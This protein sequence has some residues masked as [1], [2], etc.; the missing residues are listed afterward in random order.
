[1]DITRVEIELS[2]KCDWLPSNYEEI[3]EFMN[4][5]NTATYKSSEMGS[6]YVGFKCG[7]SSGSS[8]VYFCSECYETHKKY[9]ATNIHQADSLFDSIEYD[10]YDPTCV[11]M[12]GNDTINEERFNDKGFK[13]RYVF[14]NYS[15]RK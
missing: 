3:C 6:K 5:E 9:L 4:C 12:S 10:F 15:Y 2:T 13:G 7:G 1:M 11:K 14:R 8:Y